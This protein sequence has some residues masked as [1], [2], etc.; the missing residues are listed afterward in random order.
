MTANPTTAD[1][2]ATPLLSAKII[3]VLGWVSLGLGLVGGCTAIGTWIG[4]LIAG[5]VRIGPDWA[6]PAILVIGV[7]WTLIDVLKDGTPNRPAVASAVLLPSV[8]QAVNGKLG[9]TVHHWADQLSTW[10]SHTM[11]EWIGAGSLTAVT[12]IAI[13]LAVVIARAVLRKTK[14]NKG[15]PF[16]GGPAARARAGL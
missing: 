15:T 1:A 10:A 2:A 5:I 16:G 6:A 4:D 9:A 7:A 11:G 12:V 8:S 14:A 3:L 13:G